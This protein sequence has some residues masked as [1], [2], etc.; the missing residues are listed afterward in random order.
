MVHEQLLNALA[1]DLKIGVSKWKPKMST[2]AADMADNYVRARKKDRD[3]ELKCESRRKSMGM[4][5]WPRDQRD[6]K[7]RS[8]LPLTVPSERGKYTSSRK[9]TLD[10]EGFNCGKNGHISRHCPNNVLV[11]EHAGWRN[12]PQRCGTVNGRI[13]QVLCWI[14]NVPG[15]WSIATGFPKGRSGSENLR[16]LDVLM[17]TQSCYPMADICA[18]LDGCTVAAVSDVARSGNEVP[19]DVRRR[20]NHTFQ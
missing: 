8:R 6:S 12:G 15:L 1:R 9:E 3:P 19:G 14:P 5:P 17:G 4:K 20:D 13:V 10:R 7:R 2:E 18:E 11:C 16:W